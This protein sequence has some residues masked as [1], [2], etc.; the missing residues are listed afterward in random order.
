MGKYLSLPF[1]PL[2][3][4][5]LKVKRPKSEFH[6]AGRGIPVV[7]PRHLWANLYR[8]AGQTNGFCQRSSFL[9]AT[10][11][12]L[13]IDPSRGMCPAESSRSASSRSI[14]PSADADIVDHYQ[15][16]AQLTTDV[17][18]RALID[19]R[20]HEYA[21]RDAAA[22]FEE[23]RRLAVEVAS[24]Q[25]QLNA[26]RQL[27]EADLLRAADRE[28]ELTAQLAAAEQ[29]AHS[30][31]SR[32]AVE[33][34]ARAQVAS[35]RC[36]QAQRVADEAE[37]ERRWAVE[38]L[39]TAEGRLTKV[40][41]ERDAMRR[42]TEAAQALAREHAAREGEL[43]LL[44]EREREE[45]VAESA[46]LHERANAA[47]GEATTSALAARMQQSEAE[48]ALEQAREARRAAEAQ[49]LTHAAAEAR[50][51]T[52]VAS[53]EEELRRVEREL[54][55]TEGKAHRIGEELAEERALVLRT[56]GESAAALEAAQRHAAAE[57]E[58][59]RR[60]AAEAIDDEKKRAAEAV[61]VERQ[62]AANEKKRAAEAANDER[63]RAAE[64]VEAERRHAAEAIDDEKK[65]AAE[66]IEVER[67]RA[68]DEKKHAAVAAND[69][70]RLVAEAVE[71]ERRSG[72][73]AV[74]AACEATAERF[75]V[76]IA[77]ACATGRAVRA[78]RRMLN[79]WRQ[80]VAERARQQR[81]GGRWAVAEL[82]GVAGMAM[83]QR[84]LRDG[85]R[86]LLQVTAAR[87]RHATRHAMRGAAARLETSRLA[88]GLSA[89][90]AAADHRRWFE[91][92]MQRV[93]QRRVR[94]A[95]RRWAAR[96][97]AEALAVRTAR[98]LRHHVLFRK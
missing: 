30:S 78:R 60:R 64:A 59:A 31:D 35:W 11:E 63:Q 10:V 18:S 40:Q 4:V 93:Q 56:Q 7:P 46:R 92:G 51:T 71:A 45:R 20:T 83:R 13:M 9:M 21:L 57:L 48:H 86:G 15:Q 55:S 94:S 23:T 74:S 34:G 58:R 50:A 17:A 75:H 19:Q 72:E 95:L 25:K 1:T 97:S 47:V 42:A 90:R 82:P 14:S 37:S 2:P 54:M 49:M 6:I 68:A 85:M 66:A 79:T 8:C 53:L 29:T 12:S 24:L 32:E 62:R 3:I 61:E 87:L 76:A 39:R 43:V 80:C 98:C 84:R 36:T 69:E 5:K 88:Y 44:L 81:R 91:R 77:E 96:G 73:E 65:R 16:V 26:A 28:A 52:A 27:H 89:L 22:R 41:A 38:S 67:Q 33:L 70:R